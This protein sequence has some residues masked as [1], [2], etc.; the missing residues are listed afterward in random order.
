MELVDPRTGERVPAEPCGRDEEGR[1]VYRGRDGF[2]PLGLCEP[3]EDGTWIEA[4]REE[5]GDYTIVRR[6]D[7]FYAS[8]EGDASGPFPDVLA[9]RRF[10]RDLTPVPSP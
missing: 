9:A 8:L 6:D 3:G 4:G 10:V 2:E 7:G 1:T 5:I